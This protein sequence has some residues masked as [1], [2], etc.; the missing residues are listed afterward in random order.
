MFRPALAIPCV[1]LLMLSFACS[2]DDGETTKSSA[3]SGGDD[4]T[5]DPGE[6]GD[7]P[8]TTMGAPASAS[9]ATA[10]MASATAAINCRRRCPSTR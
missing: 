6:D 9:R 5:G 7:G 1:P 2:N 10:T 3:F 4:E 8:T